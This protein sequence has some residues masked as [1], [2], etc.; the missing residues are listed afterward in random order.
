M[1]RSAL[2]GEE[3][4]LKCLGLEG[5]VEPDEAVGRDV[6][7]PRLDGLVEGGPRVREAGHFGDEGE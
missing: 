3:S 4:V 6:E 7:Q 2:L 1:Q 5:V